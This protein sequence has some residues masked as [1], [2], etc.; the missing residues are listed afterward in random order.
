MSFT[1][2]IQSAILPAFLAC[3]ILPGPLVAEHTSSVNKHFVV[4]EGLL[5]SETAPELTLDLYLPTETTE[6]T[7]CV[8]VIQGGGFRPQ[9]GQRFRP[10]ATYLA[11]HGFAAA[12]IS[13]R[14]RPDH[15]YRDT[16]ADT[17]AAVRFIR[18]V[19]GQYNIDP[20]RI[21]AMGRSAGGTLAALLAVTGDMKELEGSVGHSKFSSRIQAAVAFAG[22]FDFIQ[23]FTDPQQI[24][25]QPRHE[26]KI[27]SNG[28]WIGAPFSPE[29]EHWRKASAATHVDKDDA[30]ILFIHCKDDATVPWIQ[31]REMHERM[32]AEGIPSAVKYYD[33]GGHGFRGLGDAPMAEMVRFFRER[34]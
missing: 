32:T 21:G 34:L 23:R 18:E 31:S 24:D 11:E 19:S 33:T 7:A 17:K 1:R 12:L 3:G 14:G 26:S 2:F 6:A 5:F 10:F 29:N 27:Q 20:D 16:I 4:Q 22:V 30:P 13:Y 8:L 25:L 28:E 9:N 15:K